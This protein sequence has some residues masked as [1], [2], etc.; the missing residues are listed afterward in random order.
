MHVQ[1]QGVE[2]RAEMRGD[3]HGVGGDRIGVGVRIGNE[4]QQNL[5]FHVELP[6]GKTP[7][8]L[9]VQGGKGKDVH[10]LNFISACTVSYHGKAGAF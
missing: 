5:G 3:S 9:G 4:R 10:E 7:A 6:R 1:R 8:S 2:I